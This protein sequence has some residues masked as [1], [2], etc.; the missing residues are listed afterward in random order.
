LPGDDPLIGAAAGGDAGSLDGVQSEP[1]EA[2]SGALVV[3]YGNPLRGDD[4]LGWH[5]STLL[6]GDPRLVGATVIWRHQL[7]PDLAADIKDAALVI[8]VDV[9]VVDEPGIV[10]VRRVDAGGSEASGSSEAATRGAGSAAASASADSAGPSSH[11]VAPAELMVLAHELWGASPEVYVVSAGAETLEIGDGLSPAV[12]AALPAV[13]D[14]VA[15]VVARHG[16][17]GSSR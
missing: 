1:A 10:S 7:T 11:H 17:P 5:A 4:A 13:V 2:A 3:C 6:A 15:S 16:D 8:L 14:A 9:N 12:E